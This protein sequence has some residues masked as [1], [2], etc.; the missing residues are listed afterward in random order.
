MGTEYSL[1]ED[2]SK[3]LYILEHSS[4][5]DLGM[6]EFG[7]ACTDGIVIEFTDLTLDEIK[8]VTQEMVNVISYFDTEYSGCEVKY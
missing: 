4:K 8:A 1:I 5:F 3:E 6:E 2:P 7:D